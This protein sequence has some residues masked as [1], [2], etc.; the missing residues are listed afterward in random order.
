MYY[1]YCC[2]LFLFIYFSNIL[3]FLLLYTLKNTAVKLQN[4]SDSKSYSENF[5][6]LLMTNE[7][8]FRWQKHYYYLLISFILFPNILTVYCYTLF[9]NTAVK[10]QKKFWQQKLPR[11]LMYSGNCGWQKNMLSDDRNIVFY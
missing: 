10:L 11:E 6:K 5:M 7:Q 8:V 1:Y 2:L 3:T 9:R 4:I